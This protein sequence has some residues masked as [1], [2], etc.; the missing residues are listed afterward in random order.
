M[1]PLLERDYLLELIAQAVA[2]IMAALRRAHELHDKRACAEVEAAVSGLVSLPED[3]AL[4]LSPE[5]LTT[6]MSLAGTGYS[7]ARYVAYALDRL[8]DVYEDMGEHALSEL[9]RAQA[10]E[11]AQRFDVDLLSVPPEMDEQDQAIF[12]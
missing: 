9:R 7:T 11:V 3:T 12:G 1:R 6:M 8:A 5:S 4:S 10:E 2:A